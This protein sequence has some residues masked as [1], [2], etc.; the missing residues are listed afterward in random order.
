MTEE[1]RIYN[2]EKTISAINNT[3]KTGPLHG[4]A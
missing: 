2:R 3:G 4:K 1:A